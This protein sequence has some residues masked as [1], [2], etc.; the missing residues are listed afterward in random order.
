MLDNSVKALA[1]T[2]ALGMGYDKPDLTFVIHYQMPGSVVA[3]YQQVGRAGRGVDAAYGVLLGGSEDADITDFFIDRA[4]PT[5][6]EVR[7]ILGALD[8][9]PNGL[10]VPELLKVVN[11]SQGRIEQA[12]KLLALESPAPIVR[13][14]SRWQ[15]TA[16]SLSNE[17]WSRAERLVELRHD[18]QRQMREY[19]ALRSGHME[20]LVRALDGNP[21]AVQHPDLPPL[22]TTIQLP[23][24][25]KAAEFLR[26]TSLPIE[27][28]KQWAS[29]L[30]ISIQHRAQTGRALCAWGDGGWAWLV[31]SGKYEHN[32]FSDELV[33]ESIKLIGEWSPQ[34]APEW[35]TCVPSRRHPTLVKDFAEQL[36]TGLGLPFRAALVKTDARSEQK[37][38]ANSVQQA[39]NIEGSLAVEQSQMLSGQV[40][41]VDD[42]VDSRWTFTF[43]A[44]PLRTNG[45]GEVWPFA[46][47][48]TGN[49]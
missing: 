21:E 27:P 3:Y 18:E 13:Q 41:L 47:A 32:H 11:V 30:P 12:T 36:A 5:Q 26:R 33:I 35:V 49:G 8:G 9:S 34:P 15:L 31:R 2:T 20:F 10:S 17:F 16:A 42:M 7:Q 37:E 6:E 46:L 29:R 39:R 24:A 28:R 45:S 38:M 23:M 22:P 1:A 40:L 4:F 25:Q 19:L 43:A 14:G 48:D 44:W